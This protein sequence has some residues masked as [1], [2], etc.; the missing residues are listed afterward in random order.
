[1]DSD[2]VTSA[3]DSILNAVLNYVIIAHCLFSRSHGSLGFR[4]NIKACPERAAQKSVAADLDT[5][6]FEQV[7][8][9]ALGLAAERLGQF[10]QGV[11][12]KFVIA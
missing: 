1:M 8:I 11:T 2:G 6:V 9:A 7:N 12:V 4:T 3:K 10:W 5:F